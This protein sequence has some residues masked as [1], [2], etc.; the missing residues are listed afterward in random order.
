MRFLKLFFLTITL[1][2]SLKPAHAEPLIIKYG[3]REVDLTPYYFAFPYTIRAISIKNKKV[4]YTKGEPK[5]G[6]YLYV[7]PWEGDALFDINIENAKQVSNVDIDDINFESHE[8]NEVLDA[9]IVMADEEKREDLN[10]WLFSE[11]N[12]KAVKLTDADYVYSFTQSRDQRT[13]VYTTR[14]GSSDHDEGCLELLTIADNGTTST[15][16]LFCDS[17]HKMPAKLNSWGPLRID[18]K[19][20]IFEAKIK[21]SRSGHQLYRFDRLTGDVK[22]L[23]N[24]TGV[25]ATWADENRFLSVGGKRLRLY[26]MLSNSSIPLNI[27]LNKFRIGAMEIAGQTYLYAITKGVSKTTF[28]VFRLLKNKLVKTD[29]FVI[30]MNARFVTAED[31]TVF[32]YKE[33]TNTLIDYERI[34]IDQ[35]GH[36]QRSDFIKGLTKLN[37]QL[38]QCMV[39]R[40]TYKSVDHIGG[41]EIKYDIDAILYEPRDP[42]AADDRLY[43]IEAFYGGRNSFSRGFHSFCQAGIT[44]LSPIVRGDSRVSSAFEKSNNGIKADAPIRDV[45]AGARYLQSKYEFADSHR[46]GTMGYSHGGWAAVRALSY[47]GPEHFEFGFALAGAGIYDIIQF[48]DDVPAGKTNIRGWFDKEFGNL[49]TRREYLSYLSA[50]SHMDRIDA[51]IFLYHGRNDERITVLHSMSFAEKLRIANKDHELVI[52]EG[53]GHAMQGA[54]SWHEI[55]GAM[56]KFLE[57]VNAGLK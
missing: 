34:D 38:A 23:I 40:V 37:D 45:I 35:A 15:Q 57:R 24:S 27:F 39:S 51:P 11:K 43:V 36:I 3:E 53:Q 7:Q 42:I 55:Y 56:F 41:F 46:I 49:K 22:K 26:N 1:W 33:S 12:S 30:N 4:Y 25:V 31:G 17:D 54:R 19:N 10:L 48:A 9:L 13:I 16:K 28:E 44:T 20:I 21:G 18:D 29:G 14:Y 52:I 50:T 6:S 8:Y 47:P 2:L 5:G 32:L